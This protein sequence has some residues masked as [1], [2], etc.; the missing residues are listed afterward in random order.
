MSKQ[1]SVRLNKDVERFVKTYAQLNNISIS[2]SIRELLHYFKLL[3]YVT[4]GLEELYRVV[5]EYDAKIVDACRH[6][7]GVKVNV[8]LNNSDIEFVDT[9]SMILNTNR[10]TALR[11]CI[12]SLY[13]I[14]KYIYSNNR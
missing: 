12:L 10:S 4:N 5:K 13:Y 7:N 8:S 2:T 11:F 3:V 14:L 1:V 9:V 6:G